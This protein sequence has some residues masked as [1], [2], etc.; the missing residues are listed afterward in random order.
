MKDGRLKNTRDKQ[1][2]REKI[3]LP[4]FPSDVGLWATRVIRSG[5]GISGRSDPVSGANV[6][7]K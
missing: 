3:T 1:Q 4:G 7:N 6:I 2:D 5:G